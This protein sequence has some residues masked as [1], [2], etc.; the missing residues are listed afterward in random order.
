MNDTCT[1]PDCKCDYGQCLRDL[2]KR[3]RPPN[4]EELAWAKKRVKEL[5]LE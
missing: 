5:G 1:F 2:R 4:P 3:I